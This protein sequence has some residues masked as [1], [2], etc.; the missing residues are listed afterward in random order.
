[1]PRN[2]Y[3]SFLGTNNYQAVRYFTDKKEES[4]PPL[5]FVQEAVLKLNCSNFGKDDKILIFTTPTAFDR[6]WKDYEHTED[7]CNGTKALKEGLESRLGNM[8]LADIYEVKEIPEGK[9]QTEIWEIFNVIFKEI[10]ENDRIIF[11]ITHSFRSLPMLNMVLINYARLLRNISVEGIYYGAFEAKEKNEAGEDCAPIW[12][13]KAFSDIQNWTN[14]ARIFLETGNAFALASQMTTDTYQ[15]IKDCLLE[16]SKFTLV[17]RG[18]DIYSGT[19]MVKLKEAFSSS[20]VEDDDPAFSALLPILDKIKGEFEDY[21]SN[22]AYNGFLAVKWC[23]NNGLLQQAATLI[24]EF[25]ITLVMLEL[26]ESQIDDKDKRATISAALTIGDDKE[27]NFK[28]ANSTSVPE[29]FVNWQKV[30]VPK[31]R[32]FEHKKAFGQLATKVKESIRNDIS[33]AGFRET[34]RD[35][36][37]FEASLIKRYKDLQKLVRRTKGIDLPSL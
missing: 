2:L 22:S 35:Y 15:V 11:D 33:H 3:I 10:N 31:V 29:S 18:M 21:Q 4:L 23:I 12:N 19:E 13:L 36:E 9:S 7:L 17:N 1:M 28:S 5:R 26:G 16:F 32:T 34:P 30:M 27:F 24:E 37:E 6:N 25:I 8:D 14:N 20:A